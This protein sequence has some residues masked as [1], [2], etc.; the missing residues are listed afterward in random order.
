MLRAP[1]SI[2]S[3]ALKGAELKLSRAHEHVTLLQSEMLRWHK[4]H[5]DPIRLIFGKDPDP[6]R[7]PLIVS[8]IENPDPVLGVIIG[9]ALHNFRCVLDYIAYELVADGGEAAKLQTDAVKYVKFPIVVPDPKGKAPADYFQEGLPNWLPGIRSVHETIVRRHQP[10]LR[11]QGA[12]MHPLA[13]MQTLSNTD[14]HRRLQ[15][16]LIVP[17][18]TSFKVEDRP[19]GC[20]V[21]GFTPG[22]DL[23]K[24]FRV[25]AELGH[26]TVANKALCHGL[27]VQPG[28][29][30]TIGFEHGLGGSPGAL[31]TF[32]VLNWI[33]N[34]INEVLSEVDAVL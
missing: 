18:K 11:G 8:S 30:V 12:E 16:V 4:E 9:D 2:V 29:T 34:E 23:D 19:L 14:K 22:P 21:L 5:P 6:R 20:E 13:L 33:G 15:P 24:G 1:V 26:Y 32:A 31:P 10:Y 3:G 28:A 27:G 25:G 7:L 17:M